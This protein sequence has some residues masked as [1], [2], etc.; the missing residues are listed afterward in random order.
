MHSMVLASPRDAPCQRRRK[1]GGS[2][3]RIAC[4]KSD[5]TAAT[6]RPSD[7][8]LPSIDG[9]R[10]FEAAARLGTF[11]RAADELA[12]T[13]SA[14]GKRVA[15]IESLLGAPVFTRTSK[16][17]TLTASRR[18]YLE[19]VRHALTLGAAIPAMVALATS[20][21]SP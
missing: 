12:V 19:Q 4:R 7:H 13:A 2:A 20:G 5:W 1:P 11:E 15:M 10:A 6:P 21:T 16:A 17:L 14:M 3:Q 8:R 18:E 9:R